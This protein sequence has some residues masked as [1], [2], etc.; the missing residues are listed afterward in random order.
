MLQK[1]HVLMRADGPYGIPQGPGWEDY[2]VLVII[3][4]GIGKFQLVLS[5]ASLV[6]RR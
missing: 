5:L 6:S 1:G 4:G 2:N 3:A